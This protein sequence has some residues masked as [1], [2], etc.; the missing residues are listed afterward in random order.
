MRAWLASLAA[1]MAAVGGWVLYTFPPAGSRFY[2][3]C[4]FYALTGL[5]CPGCGSTRA[6]HHLVHGR[7]DEAFLMNPFLFAVVAMLLAAL[8]SF[9][10]GEQPAFAT[11]PWFSW[12]AAI[13][14]IGWWIGRNVV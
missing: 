4:V 12:G 2:P 8:P 7:V 6:L 14:T 1:A 11:K 9:W 3:Q 13:V 10:R 5:E